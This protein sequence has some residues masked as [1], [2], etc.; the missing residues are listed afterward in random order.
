MGQ[1]PY[2][3]ESHWYGSKQMVILPTTYWGTEGW[4]SR[5]N[6]K[7]VRTATEPLQ[8]PHNTATTFYSGDCYKIATEIMESFPKQTYRNRCIIVDPVGKP[9][10]LTVPVKRVDSK[11]L[12]RDVEIS[13]QTKWQH[14]HWNAIMSA[15]K[16]TPYFDYYQDYIRPLYEKE[17]R[18]LVDLNEQTFCIVEA[19]L[20][21][22]QPGKV[23][24]LP[25]TEDWTGQELE[26]TWGQDTCIL[27]KLFHLGPETR[28]DGQRPS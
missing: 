19:L 28:V 20:R 18:W 10:V 5:F 11:Q 22:E 2:S 8:D 26:S 21:N 27:D 1:G 9:I 3:L 24:P 13:Y 6:I 14:Q 15:Y 7:K 17:T 4:W 12:T 16:K 25:H 23:Q